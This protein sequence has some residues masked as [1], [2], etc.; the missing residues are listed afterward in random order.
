VVGLARA[1]RLTSYKNMDLEIPAHV[2]VPTCQNC[3]A[4]WIDEPTAAALDDALEVGYQKKLR[5]RMD[6]ALKVIL[7]EEKSQTR[8]E[9]L[10]GVSPGYLSKLKLG[11][12]QPSAEIVSMLALVSKS[13]KRRLAELARFYRPHDGRKRAAG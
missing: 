12:R 7:T 5:E 3:G 1:G 10:L 2:V 8:I 4:T 13:P 6:T 11:K 9:Q